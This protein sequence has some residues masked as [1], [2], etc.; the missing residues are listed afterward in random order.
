MVFDCSSR[1]SILVSLLV[2]FM[3]AGVGWAEDLKV[4]ADYDTIQEA[5]N[6]ANPQGGDTVLVAP[7]T[8]EENITLSNIMLPCRAKK[9]RA[10]Y[11]NP[12]TVPRSSP[13]MV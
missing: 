5:I 4:P 3:W 13:L 2:G 7:G 11:S 8:Y 1:H 10:P 6:A 12:I 9:P